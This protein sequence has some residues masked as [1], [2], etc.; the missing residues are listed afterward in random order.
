MS[1]QTEVTRRKFLKDGVITGASLAA[2]SGISFITNPRRVF[3][4]NDRIR[5]GLIGVETAARRT[6]KRR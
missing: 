6:C 4:A 2:L 1:K 5:F 3:G